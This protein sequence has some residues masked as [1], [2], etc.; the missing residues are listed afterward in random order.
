MFLTVLFF[1]DWAFLFGCN[2]K[3]QALPYS[4][5]SHVFRD[6]KLK[7]KITVFNK[8]NICLVY[9]Y[10]KCVSAR[11]YDKSVDYIYILLIFGITY[12]HEK[13]CAIDW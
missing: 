6:Q 8:R 11:L 9:I 1:G 10:M 12:D 13:D 2:N 4:S 3:I 7:V 5:L